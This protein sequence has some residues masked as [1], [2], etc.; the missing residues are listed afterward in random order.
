MQCTHNYLK[1]ITPQ[2]F[3][4]LWLS[5]GRRLTIA[6]IK[7]HPERHKNKEMHQARKS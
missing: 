4:S 5:H 3:F 2:Y 1:V 7:Q 6:L